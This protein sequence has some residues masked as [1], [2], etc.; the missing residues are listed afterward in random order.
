MLRRFL[1]K[2]YHHLHK[3]KTVQGHC[4]YCL[5]SGVNILLQGRVQRMT[6]T[7]PMKVSTIMFY[8]SEGHVSLNVNFI[9]VGIFWIF[10]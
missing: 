5:V 3:G 10:H 9:P 4:V 7:Y 6:P 8:H 1:C 2:V